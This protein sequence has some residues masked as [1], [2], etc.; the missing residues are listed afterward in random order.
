MPFFLHSSTTGRCI[1]SVP[2]T[3][4]LYSI[5]LLI[6]LSRRNQNVLETTRIGWGS[7]IR[8]TLHQRSS[9]NLNLANPTHEKQVIILKK[10]KFEKWIFRIEEYTSGCSSSCFRSLFSKSSDILSSVWYRNN[11]VWNHG[12]IHFHIIRTIWEFD[13]EWMK[14]SWFFFLFSLF[15]LKT[16]FYSIYIIIDLIFL[17][18]FHQYILKTK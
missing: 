18:S 12:K 1:H 17:L 13:Y 6:V 3:R 16:L 15:T 9:S 2:P 8:C 10:N 11:D 4:W 14:K 5:C 7:L